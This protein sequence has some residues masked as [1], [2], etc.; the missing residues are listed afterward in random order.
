[1]NTRL[2]KVCSNCNKTYI[3]GDKFCRFCGAPLGRAKYIEDEFAMIY[4]PRPMKRF[5][6]CQRCGYEW[7]TELMVDK[8][9]WC[10]KCGGEAPFTYKN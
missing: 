3:E 9:A 4:G 2:R 1:M 6:K 7:E 5:H 8:Q 10:P